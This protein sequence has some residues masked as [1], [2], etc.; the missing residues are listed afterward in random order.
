MRFA[1]LALAL[2]CVTGARAAE[3]RLQK[4]LND[5]TAVKESGY[6]I[7]NDLPQALAAAKESGKPLLAVLR[8]IP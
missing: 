4:V 8:C 7:Y 2:S 6:W 5:A 1:V 3:D